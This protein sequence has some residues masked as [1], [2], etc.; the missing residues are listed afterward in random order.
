MR[1][2]GH[3]TPYN[4]NWTGLL[5]SLLLVVHIKQITCGF[6]QFSVPE[7]LEPGTLVGS[8]RE[9]FSPPYQLLTQEYLR[10]DTNTG[11]IFT[12][13][14]K[15]DREGLCPG[16]TNDEEC[17][18]LHNAI[19]GPSEDLIQFL[20]IIEDINDNAPH[21]KNSE[22]HLRVPEDVAVGTSFPLDDQAQDR[23]TGING[24][25][26]Y[27]LEGAGGVFTLKV[28]EDKLFIII[29]VQKA[30]DRE[31]QDVYLMQLV[32]TDCGEHPLN[33]SSSLIVT[34]TDVN[35]N[36]PSFSSD[37]PGS[38]TIQGDSPKNMVV[39]QVIATDPD[40]G[41][42]AA[43]IYSLSPKVSQRAKKL[44]SLNSHTGHIQLAQDLHSDKSEELVLKVLATGPHCPPAVTQ[45]TISVLPKVTQ[46]LTI[47]ISF[48]AEHQ[49][50]TVVLPENQ[51]PTVLAVLE[52]EGDSSFKGSSLAIE[53]DVP[54]SLSP[55]NGKYLL[56]TSKSLDYEMKREHIISVV[57][58]SRSAEGSVILS[59]RQ[60][61]KVLVADVNDNAPHFSQ[62]QYQQEVE[63]NNQP[64]MSLMQVS[65]SDA[66]SGYNGRVTYKLHKYTSA[67]FN[68][69][70]VTGQLSVLAPLDREQQGVYNITVF[71]RDC[72]SPPLESHATIIIRVL[73]QNDNA[74][75]FVTPHFIFF[76]PEN[77]PPLAQVGKIEVKDPDE[78]ANGNIGL[79]VINSSA[80]FVV[81]NRQGTLRTTTN[82][83]RETEDRHELYILASDNGHPVALT[84]IARVTV[85]VEDINDNQ[86]KVILPSS[87]SS[88]LTVS[89][90]TL[91]GTM[92][93][94]IYAIDKDSGVNSEI[95]YSVVAKEP[96]QESS[97]F[98]VDPRSG[99][100][101]LSQQLLH[102]DLGMH[103]LFIVVRDSGKPTPL[104]TT[105][106]INLLVNESMEHCYLDKVPEW[107]WS[108]DLI[109]SPS[110]ASI[111]ERDTSI[112]VILFISLGMF[113]AS[114]VF[115]ITA[116]FCLKNRSLQK[117][118]RTN[119]VENEI[120]LRLKDKYYSDE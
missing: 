25:V 54:F 49:N 26:Q 65:A 74:P 75:V 50:Q 3:G 87:N 113:L 20:V 66:D 53:G 28:E 48:I 98:Q 96:P 51:P 102:E 12:T 95:T 119:M 118:R 33:A 56:S 68:M 110:K 7:E 77:A 104:Y 70:S 52:L 22:I 11:N 29:V 73:D 46:E 91:A 19:V 55:Q 112:W 15:M 39:T 18:I 76:I 40:T 16:E 13:E 60:K 43:I 99:N 37:S 81:D 35:D 4:M 23:D 89:P 10:M 30:L 92:V 93:T 105:I 5:Q 120:P 1:A 97:P 115:F 79:Q 72:G 106:W 41:P 27:H 67:I 9:H 116:C 71:A 101:T 58:H 36:C 42:N 24:E 100:I 63:E 47:K 111:C 94:K 90:G 107:T 44:F 83:D 2:M 38:V 88:C 109:Q 8:L 64:G 32:A 31:T 17:I 61:I 117:N 114:M 62:S 78:G 21:F 86:P 69:D 84:S 6:V 108:S 34:V 80:T 57:V 82:L 59:L 85:F 103:H 45:V 14:Q